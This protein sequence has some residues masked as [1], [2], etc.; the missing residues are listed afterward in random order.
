MKKYFESF[1][2]ICAF[3][4]DAAES[5]LG[6]LDKI[7][8]V[9]SA[10]DVFEECVEEYKRSINI[11]LDAL[12]DRCGEA[13]ESAGVHKYA[14]N[15]IIYCLWTEHLRNL[16]KEKGYDDTV[17]L[18]SVTDLRTKAIECKKKYGV[19]GTFVGGWLPQYFSLERFALG[20]LQFEI[21]DFFASHETY[22]KFGVELVPDTSKAAALHIPSTGPLTRDKVLDSYKK[23]Y[24]FFEKYFPFCLQNGILCGQ[25]FSW[26]LYGPVR[27]ILPPDS[28]SRD[29]I[30]DFDVMY[31]YDDP[32]YKDCWRIFNVDWTGD[33]SLLP[34]DTSMQRRYADHLAAGGTGG[35]GAGVMLFDGENVLTR[36]E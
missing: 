5:L 36:H 26:L 19:W 21:M 30:R 34:R 32:G 28:N 6:D 15:L 2:K 10:R 23:A 27:N 9:R 18:D 14:G 35:R 8:A 1:L 31:D 13:A 7:C 20:R 25:C 22:T 4:T 3:P 12:H 16:Y 29:F 17:W 11:D 33:A 24:A